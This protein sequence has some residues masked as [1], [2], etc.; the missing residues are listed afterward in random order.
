MSVPF[1]LLLNRANFLRDKN[2]ATRA[3][4]FSRAE[5]CEV[6]AIRALRHWAH[7]TLDLAMVM[8][9]SWLIFSGA[10]EEVL[11]K[12]EEDGE[13]TVDVD[14]RLGNAIEMAI[15]SDAKRFIKSSASQKIIGM[16]AIHTVTHTLLTSE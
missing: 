7:D 2:I 12:V 11:V 6:L 14:I 13:E 16:C 4:S 8:T 1:C 5:L 15:L 10:G 9:T 3:L